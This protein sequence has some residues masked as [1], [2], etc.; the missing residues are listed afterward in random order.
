[1][2]LYLTMDSEN[3]ITYTPDWIK[4]NYPLN[5]R[6]DEIVFDI[7]GEIDYS[8]NCLNCRCKGELI[9]W[10]LWEED[11]D[12]IDLQNMDCD[13]VAAMLTEKQIAEIICNSDYFCVGIYPE[14]NE[15]DEDMDDDRYFELAGVDNWKIGKGTFEAFVD[16]V[17]YVREFEFEA[18]LNI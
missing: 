15:D 2:K 14:Y 11:G 1:M 3:G 5:G 7:R 10:V 8:Q 6:E 17:E 16:N 18:E 9:P 4:V 13:E 12:E